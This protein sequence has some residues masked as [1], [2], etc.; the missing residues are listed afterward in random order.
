MRH[1]SSERDQFFCYYFVGYIVLHV[2]RC[3]GHDRGATAAQVEHP[4]RAGDSINREL[5][6]IMPR[7]DAPRLVCAVAAVL[8]ALAARGALAA[9]AA[10]GTN[11]ELYN[12]VE[13]KDLQQW[14]KA[15]R[16]LVSPAAYFGT[17]LCRCQL[18]IR[19]RG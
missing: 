17:E 4:L 12:W 14:S 16:C 3:L 13:G 18:V 6:L 15:G 2:L 10:P 1:D 7:M 11:M 5:D 9:P 19:C 8:T